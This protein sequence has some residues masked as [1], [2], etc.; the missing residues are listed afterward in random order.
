M[1]VTRQ[2]I[3]PTE[4]ASEAISSLHTQSNPPEAAISQTQV[5]TTRARLNVTACLYLSPSNSARS[6]STLIAVDVEKD[7]PHKIKDEAP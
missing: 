7:T 1:E 6:L 3:E 5:M 4:V 2:S